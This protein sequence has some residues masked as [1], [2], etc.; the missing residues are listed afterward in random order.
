MMYNFDGRQ[1]EVS[2]GMLTMEYVWQNT[3]PDAT[4]SDLTAT[5]I[6]YGNKAASKIS[7][8]PTAF[9]SIHE[10]YAMIDRLWDDEAFATETSRLMVDF[11][12]SQGMKKAQAVI[13]EGKKKLAQAT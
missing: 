12:E 4:G 8:N 11:A 1:V 7:G 5:L 9:A 6:F 3:M 2:M 13:E 10:V